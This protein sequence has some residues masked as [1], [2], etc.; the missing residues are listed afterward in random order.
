MSH[1]QCAHADHKVI[2]SIWFLDPLIEICLLQFSVQTVKDE[3]AG[4]DGLGQTGADETGAATGVKNSQLGITSIPCNVLVDRLHG[5]S[6]RG[7]AKPVVVALIG[8]GPF[9]I[10]LL[11]LRISAEG[12]CAL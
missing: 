7:V 8:V 9:V 6:G 5:A 11:S 3:L 2:A 4:Q 1:G 10:E 12:V